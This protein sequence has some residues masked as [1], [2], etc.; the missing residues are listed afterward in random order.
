MPIDNDPSLPFGMIWRR[1]WQLSGNYYVQLDFTIRSLGNTDNNAQHKQ[2]RPGYACLGIC[3]GSSC[4]HESWSGSQ[5]GTHS[6]ILR[7]LGTGN[8]GAEAS[9]MLLLTDDGKF[10]LYSHATDDLIPLNRDTEVD[11]GSLEPMSTGSL[12]L[13]VWGN[14]NQYSNVTGILSINNSVY[15]IHLPPVNRIS[16][17]NGYVGIVSRGQLDFE[18]TRFALDPGENFPLHYS[19]NELHTCYVLGDTLQYK[20]GSWRCTFV[21]ICRSEGEQV[22]IKISD[23]ELLAP[24][25]EILSPSGTSRIVNN[26]FRLNTAIIEVILPFDPSERTMYYTVWKD[27][28]NVT[29]DDRIGTQSVGI[30]TGFKEGVPISGNYVGR[31]PRLTAPYRLCGMSTRAIHESHSEPTGTARYEA[32][33]IHDQPTEDAFRHFESYNFQA[34]IWED[35][36]WQLASILPPPTTNDAYKIINTTLAGPTSR[37]Q[38]MRHWNVLNP[39]DSEYGMEDSKGPEQ[40]IMRTQSGLGQDVNY[41]RRNFQIVQH[42]CRGEQNPNPDENPSN[43]RRWRMPAKDLS[44]YILDSRSWRSSQDTNIWQQQGWGHKEN[45]YGRSAP[46]RT[47]LGEEQYGWLSSNLST[48]GSHQICLTGINGL[49]TIWAGVKKNPANGSY[50][51]QRDRIVAKYAGWSKEAAERLLDLISQRDGIVSLYGGASNA[52][53][54]LNNEHGVC[55]C[56]FGPAAQHSGQRL[57]NETPFSQDLDGRS[58]Q[59]LAYYGQELTTPHLIPNDGPYFWNF[60][61]MEFYTQNSP[62]VISFAIRN[63]IDAPTESPRGGG[64][65]YLRSEET[66]RAARSMLPS[67]QLI[68]DADVQ[69]SLLTGEAV[70]GTRTRSDGTINSTKLVEIEPHTPV[71]IT[72]YSADA[73]DSIIIKTIPISSNIAFDS[74]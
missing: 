18:C 25:W 54:L 14:D 46:S 15:T 27:G 38:M 13:Y 56:C 33:F 69:I 66:G 59:L 17:T 65:V 20:D 29:G 42:L 49:H 34:I 40:L 68:P 58:I 71:L 39:G 7:S 70:R 36:I 74:G 28:V 62:P 51:H 41:M 72:A 1:D 8:V 9:W 45:L 57:L 4:L 21:A 43:W 23:R 24:E 10:G 35:G 31:L 52:C 48:D 55:E 22:S 50:F 32:W 2:L 12:A 47:L 5:S 3:F 53:I 60:M 63:I 67:L 6:S 61:D 44:I 19:I 73:S 64:K 11:M 16:F 37:W 30:G 26:E